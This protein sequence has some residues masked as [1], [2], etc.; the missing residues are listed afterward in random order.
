MGR[1]IMF[2]ADAVDMEHLIRFIQQC[3]GII[4]NE[5]GSVLDDDDLSH[6]LEPEYLESKFPYVDLWIKLENS[7]I[8]Y[9]YYPK[10]NRTSLKLFE[11]EAIQ[12]S[13]PSSRKNEK[14]LFSWG[15]FWYAPKSYDA[16][17]RILVKNP[18]LNILYN[19][20]KRYIRKNYRISRDKLTYIAPH[21]YELYKRGEYLPG[22]H[23]GNYVSVF[24]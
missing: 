3:N 20:L 14:N 12:F 17:G 8:S 22:G 11:S 24:D 2:Y 6:I 21:C 15:R 1:Q 23:S 18:D 4:I 13:R 5:D 9:D 10:S 19:A 16:D 7:L